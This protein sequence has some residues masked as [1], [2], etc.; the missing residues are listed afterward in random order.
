M[1]SLKV[2]YTYNWQKIVKCSTPNFVEWIDVENRLAL[3]I[4]TKKKWIFLRRNVH[5]TKHLKLF[6]FCFNLLLFKLQICKSQVLV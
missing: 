1:P 5:M 2:L 6:C 3:K 4:L